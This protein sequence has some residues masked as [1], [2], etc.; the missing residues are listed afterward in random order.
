MHAIELLRQILKIYKHIIS[1]KIILGPDNQLLDL[2]TLLNLLKCQQGLEMLLSTQL[3]CTNKS[4]LDDDNKLLYLITFH[5]R[6]CEMQDLRDRNIIIYN[7][8]HDRIMKYTT[9]IPQRNN[10]P[11]N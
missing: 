8:L 6:L 5:P 7:I 4:I 10:F 2:E 1:N 3:P 11:R 9:Q